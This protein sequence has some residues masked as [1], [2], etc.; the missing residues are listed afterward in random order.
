MFICFGCAG[1]LL[2][3]GPFSSCEEWGLVSSCRAQASHWSGF[4]SWGAGAPRCSGF[5]SCGTWLERTGSIDVV[6]V[7]NCSTGCGIFLDQ[8]SKLHLLHWQVDS[9][10][11]SPQGSPQTG[12]SKSSV[13]LAR[14]QW[15]YWHSFLAVKPFPPPPIYHF[16]HNLQL[17]R[18]CLLQFPA[19]SIQ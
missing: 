6:R 1:S 10:P 8:G 2:L 9:L 19:S 3:T 4:F 11:L 14:H 15:L 16:L 12:V 18:P 13:Q 7:L 17:I 5:S